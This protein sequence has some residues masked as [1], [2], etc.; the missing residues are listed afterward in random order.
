MAKITIAFA[1][2]KFADAVAEILSGNGFEL[3]RICTSAD[4]VIRAFHTCE[5]GILVTGYRLKDRTAKEL[6]EDLGD[7]AEVLILGTH[8]Q[9]ER[10]NAAEAFKL[11]L[12]LKK[13]A[14]LSAVEILAQLHYRNM[15]HRSE[16]DS[17]VV[18]QAKEV[19]MKRGMSEHEAHKF[20][21]K[22]SMRFGLRMEQTAKRILEEQ[23]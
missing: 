1:E 13:E 15:P 17:K 11:Q 21:Q 5:D 19:L 12:P 6:L 14:L 3:F 7:T 20:L 9:L 22:T 4:E 10:I 23:Q 2:R 8:E 18:E 16:E